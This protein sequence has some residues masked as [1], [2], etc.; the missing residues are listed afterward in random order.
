MVTDCV[1]V[2][3]TVCCSWAVFFRSISHPHLPVQIKPPALVKST[4]RLCLLEWF[5]EAEACPALSVHMVPQ[6]AWCLSLSCLQINSNSG[7][8]WATACDRVMDD[9]TLM[10]RCVIHASTSLSSPHPLI[11]A[12]QRQGWRGVRVYVSASVHVVMRARSRVVR[13]ILGLKVAPFFQTMDLH[14]KPDG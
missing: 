11:L 14:V 12:A 13:G 2:S 8:S 3:D 6:E 7:R 10:C 1:H 5:I 4:L 9:V